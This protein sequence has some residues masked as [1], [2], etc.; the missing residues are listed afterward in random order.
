MRREADL[1]STESSKLSGRR[2]EREGPI[3]HDDAAN[4]ATAA[5]CNTC[6]S[7]HDA[8]AQW[9]AYCCP[10][11]ALACANR[12]AESAPVSR[13][14]CRASSC[15]F[16]LAAGF[17]QAAPSPSRCP[18]WAAIEA[19]LAMPITRD[20]LSCGSRCQSRSSISAC[21][22]ARGHSSRARCGHGQLRSLGMVGGS[23]PAGPLSRHC[24]A[25]RRR[26]ARPAPRQ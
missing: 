11:A 22:R 4:P 8:I 9:R 19:L 6:T 26:P 14:C 18:F 25:A 5:A 16:L 1:V 7:V 13:A 20:A 3:E 24:R 12:A 23:A 15:T 17:A 21:E 10:S 2:E